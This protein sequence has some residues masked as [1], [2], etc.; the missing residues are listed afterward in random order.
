MRPMN[1]QVSTEY[2]SYAAGATLL[3][4][5]VGHLAAVDA[6]P[7]SDGRFRRLLLAPGANISSGPPASP[8]HSPRNGQPVPAAS[9][10]LQT[11]STGASDYILRVGGVDVCYLPDAI[12][13]IL[14]VFELPSKPDSAARTQEQQPS[15][16]LR[17][18]GA[19][20]ISP[21]DMKSKDA[22]QTADLKPV[23]Y[24]VYLVGVTLTIVEAAGAAGPAMARR[25][26]AMTSVLLKHSRGSDGASAGRMHVQDAHLTVSGGSDEG[27]RAARSLFGQPISVS[28]DYE[29]DARGSTK[30]NMQGSEL[31][32]CGNSLFVDRIGNVYIAVFDLRSADLRLFP[33][34]IHIPVT[35]VH[36]L[37]RHQS[38]DGLG[39]GS[40]WFICICG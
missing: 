22:L 1:L 32:V 11:D 20:A 17:P 9:F 38:F 16:S 10:E 34:Q 4:V 25:C 15:P 21:A 12:A 24:H 19:V 35:G 29:L 6:R 36:Q 2:I 23:T 7:S 27:A 14:R 26:T 5:S 13:P 31:E 28:L 40:F 3:R 8:A 37:S 33:V 18:K 39:F 30:A